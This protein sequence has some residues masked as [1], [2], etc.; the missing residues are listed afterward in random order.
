MNGYLNGDGTFTYAHDGSESFSDSFTYKVNDG[1]ND[2]NVAT[3]SITI[4]PVNDNLP[5]AND[6]AVTLDAGATATITVLSNDSDADLPAD[7][8]SVI[9]VSGPAHGT[10]T[11]NA[12][13]TFTYVHDGSADLSDSFTYKLNDGLSDSNVATV[14]ITI[15]PTVV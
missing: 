9:Q 8:L 13:G 4:T 3:V 6:D 14:S 1:L 11:L 12:D 7:T 10:L 5:L 15:T 2:S